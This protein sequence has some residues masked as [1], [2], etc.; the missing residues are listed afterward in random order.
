ML[1]YGYVTPMAPLLLHVFPSFAIGGQQTRFATIANRLGHA[2]RHRIISLDEGDS[3]IDLLDPTLDAFLVPNR[4]PSRNPLA[5]FRA[6]ARTINDIQPDILLTYNWG[7]IEWAIANRMHRHRPHL[8]LEDGFGP[9]EAD[10]QK[11]RRVF[12]RQLFLTHS[13]LIVPSQNL[14]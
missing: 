11:W 9:D 1:D 10:Q 6:I 4:L 2:F 8:H 7:A 13:T 12:T 3:A 14:L 5:L